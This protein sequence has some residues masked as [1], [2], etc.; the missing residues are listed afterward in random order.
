MKCGTI[1]W[2]N[3]GKPKSFSGREKWRWEIQSQ[4]GLS[5][6]E[7][8]RE[9][10]WDPRSQHEVMGKLGRGKG[11]INQLFHSFI[12]N[13]LLGEYCMPDIILLSVERVRETQNEKMKLNERQWFPDLSYS[14]ASPYV[15]VL[16]SSEHVTKYLVKGISH[17]QRI[18]R[19]TC[20][21][22]E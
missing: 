19:H 9:L 22:S 10:L 20:N 17:R 4:R 8:T 5:G 1:T 16:F 15:D 14:W 18:L 6:G 13:C 12:C 11:N 3:Q 21:F 2:Q 7:N